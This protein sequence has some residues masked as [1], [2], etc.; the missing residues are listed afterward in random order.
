ME[1]SVPAVTISHSGIVQ[2]VDAGSVIVK[3]SSAAACA[4]C[5]AEGS[6]ILSG[7]EE[8]V[9][10][11]SGGYNVYPGDQV[12]VLM[13]Q[14]MGYEALFLGYL[15]PLLVLIAVLM[16]LVSFS[17]PELIAGLLSVT[18]LIPYYII[19]YFFRT[20]INRKFRFTIKT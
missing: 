20:R 12:T 7:K 16:L 17:I 6:C 9:V 18:A 14:S 11:I 19:L 4:G 10:Q 5:H 2:R 13:K 3:I 8:K 15:I 1:K